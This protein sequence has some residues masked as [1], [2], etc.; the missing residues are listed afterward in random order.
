MTGIYP[1][2][3]LDKASE[4]QVNNISIVIRRDTAFPNTA[5]VAAFRTTKNCKKSRFWKVRFPVSGIRFLTALA[6]VG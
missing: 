4:T 5:W 3:I 1:A 2:P 6:F